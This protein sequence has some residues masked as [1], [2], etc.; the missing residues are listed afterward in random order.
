MCVAA[1]V[2]VIQRIM[3]TT[4]SISNVSFPREPT[5][6]LKMPPRATMIISV[7]IFIVVSNCKCV[8]ILEG[9]QD[10]ECAIGKALK[11]SDYIPDTNMDV[12][13][14][15]ECRCPDGIVRCLPK[16]GRCQEFKLTHKLTSKRPNNLKNSNRSKG[17]KVPSIS[18][19]TKKPNC[20]KLTICGAG[21]NP[22]S[23]HAPEYTIPLGEVPA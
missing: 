6:R 22:S 12:L 21:I 7:S 8:D 15:F 16:S 18:T 20:S 17:N 19:T 5:L 4:E 10:I 1:F 11:I 23:A 9:G 3:T 2:V 13:K 14:C